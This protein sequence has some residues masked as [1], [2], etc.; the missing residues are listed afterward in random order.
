MMGVWIRFYQYCMWLYFFAVSLIKTLYFKLLLSPC[1]IQINELLLWY[2][3]FL[4]RLPILFRNC[5]VPVQL[6]ESDALI[7][8]GSPKNNS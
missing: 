2:K 5:S 3:P 6:Q 7:W 1:E 8:F 4:N